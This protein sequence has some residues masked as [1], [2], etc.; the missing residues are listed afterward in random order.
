MEMDHENE[1]KASQNKSIVSKPSFTNDTIDEFA[2]LMAEASQVL[3]VEPSYVPPSEAEVMEIGRNIY[4]KID[5]SKRGYITKEC[6]R[7]YAINQ[8]AEVSPDTVFNEADFEAGFKLLDPDADGRLTLIDIIGF[9]KKRL[10]P[11]TIL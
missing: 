1:Q 5:V 9:T 11:I 6:L 4:N 7:R 10:S 3:Y 2:E 8:L